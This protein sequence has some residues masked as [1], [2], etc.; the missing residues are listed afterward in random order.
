M[1]DVSMDYAAVQ[2]MAD[3]FKSSADTL[4]AVDRSLEMAVAIL[5][6]SAFVG[7]VGN[8]ALASYLDNIQ[9]HVR[10]V[11]STCEELHYDLVGAILS[12]RDGDYSGSQ[13]FA[14]SGAGASGVSRSHG[15]AVATAHWARWQQVIINNRPAFKFTGNV[16]D[17]VGMVPGTEP[18]ALPA[19]VALT[20]LSHYQEEPY[21]VRGGGIAVFDTAMSYGIGKTPP[22]MLVQGA[23]SA[24]Q[25]LGQ[26]NVALTHYWADTWD[27]PPQLADAM[28]H[29]ADNYSAALDRLD[30]ANFRY[31]VARLTWDFH[32]QQDHLLPDT[33]KLWG[34][35]LDFGRS[36]LWDIPNAQFD[37]GFTQS[38]GIATDYINRTGLPPSVKSSFNNA[39][40]ALASYV[41]RASFWDMAVDLIPR[42]V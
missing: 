14:G 11:A 3:G 25:I 30:L 32:L 15:G 13:R 1:A 4:E 31:D 12:L 9:G 18:I 7:M 38:A 29:S 35:T 2:A 42:P 20:Y 26:G 28:R 39:A 10:R 40:A 5:R 6:A 27:V 33:G 24:A 41:E 37:L 8:W 34:T 16:V 22:G 23:N 19:G 21:L 17:L 36:Y